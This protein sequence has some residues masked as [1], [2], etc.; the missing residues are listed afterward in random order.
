MTVQLLTRLPS[1]SA[2]HVRGPG[3]FNL[4]ASL[5]RTFPLH[6]SFNLD[7][8]VESFDVT[9]TPQFANPA[10]DISAGGFGTITSSNANR[11]LRVS[12]RLS[13]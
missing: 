4:D 11:T 2:C 10:S 12:G 6:E 8:M 13:F 7:L 1:R 3:L 9:N 5:K